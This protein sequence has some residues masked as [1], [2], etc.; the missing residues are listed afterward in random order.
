MHAIHVMHGYLSA[1]ILDASV[2][3][4][5]SNIFMYIEL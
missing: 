4:F 2:H 5:K 1:E 3:K